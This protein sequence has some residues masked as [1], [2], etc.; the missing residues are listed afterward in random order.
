MS[1]LSLLYHFFSLNEQCAYGFSSVYAFNK[2]KDA[3]LLT[4]RN[5]LSEFVLNE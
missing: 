1:A 2:L 4:V 5:M 3:V